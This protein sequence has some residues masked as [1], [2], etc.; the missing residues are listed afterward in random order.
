MYMV[1]YTNLRIKKS[2]LEKLNKMKGESG[3]VADV[4]EKMLASYKGCTID[5]IQE[6]ERDSVAIRL[7]YT[8]FDGNKNFS[9]ESEYGITYQ[10]LKLGKVGDEFTANPNP[11]ADEYMLDTAKILYV[12]DRSV[13]VRVTEI[14]KDGDNELSGVHMVHVDLF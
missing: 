3:T 14:V 1:D 5:D 8:V 10:E 7:E 11:S 13:L 6:I 12:D 9:I 4:I 2:T